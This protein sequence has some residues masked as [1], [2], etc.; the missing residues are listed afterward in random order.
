MKWKKNDM[1]ENVYMNKVLDFSD[2]SDNSRFY[3][4]ENKKVIGNIED[5]TKSVSI[6]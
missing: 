3:D 4:V 2:C 1:Y 6:V 5:E